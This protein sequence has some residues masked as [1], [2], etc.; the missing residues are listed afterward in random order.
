MYGLVDLSIRKSS[1]IAGGCLVDSFDYS[2]NFSVSLQMLLVRFGT[3][4]QY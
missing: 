4:Y 1:R 3:P 2:G